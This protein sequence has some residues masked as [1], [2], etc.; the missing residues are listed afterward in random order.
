MHNTHPSFYRKLPGFPRSRDK[1]L[2]RQNHSGPL[3]PL[4]K[5]DVNSP[6][7]HTPASAVAHGNATQ[8]LKTRPGTQSILG[9]Q[10]RGL[11]LHSPDRETLCWL[12]AMGAAQTAPL[13]FPFLLIL[14]SWALL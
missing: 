1:T 10:L 9:M 12:T 7:C 4:V 6:F 11:S 13:S 5:E 3:A 14:L 8:E 2:H